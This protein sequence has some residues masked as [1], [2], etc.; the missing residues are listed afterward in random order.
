MIPGDSFEIERL[1][2]VEAGKDVELTT[3]L[4]VS[5]GKDLE[6]GKPYVEGAKVVLTVKGNLRGPKTI[7][8]KKKRR[9]GY[10]SLGGSP[11]GADGGHGQV[12]LT[13]KGTRRKPSPVKEIHHGRCKAAF[14]N[15]RDSNPQYLGVKR[16]GA[17]SSRRA[18]CSCVSAGR[19]SLA[20]RMSAWA[21][22]IRSF[23]LKA[24]TVKFVK[25]SKVVTIVPP[26]EEKK[27]VAPKVASRNSSGIVGPLDFLG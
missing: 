19:S 9:K 22:I 3:V 12:N 26:P 18:K 7:N 21:A 2:G 24:G 4:A 14:K 23:A 1:E 15:G 16:F 5:D 20:A 13:C 27:E 8:F 6:I 17:K 10:A 11:S 25:D